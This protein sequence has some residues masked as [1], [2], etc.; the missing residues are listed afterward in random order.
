MR[1][2]RLGES[3]TW[4]QYAQIE[5]IGIDSSQFSLLSQ[6]SC[7]R[8][9]RLITKGLN[10]P[11]GSNSFDVTD[12]MFRFVARR[13][14]TDVAIWNLKTSSCGSHDIPNALVDSESEIVIGL[15]VL[16]DAVTSAPVNM[17]ST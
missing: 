9:F 1:R 14:I 16:S 3:V 5:F 7:S 17:S 11:R 2:Q 4:D 13:P 15:T 8:I 10:K 12:N 6:I